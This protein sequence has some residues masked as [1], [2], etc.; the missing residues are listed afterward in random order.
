M[1]SVSWHVIQHEGW[2]IA[3]LFFA[4]VA[5]VAD[6]TP[7]TSCHTNRLFWLDL[8]VSKASKYVKGTHARAAGL[9]IRSSSRL[10]SALSAV[11]AGKCFIKRW[12]ASTADASG[13]DG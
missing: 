10:G 13:G 8:G 6:T 9:F 12:L 2:G 4:H 1:L 7:V 3:Q 11:E 5:S